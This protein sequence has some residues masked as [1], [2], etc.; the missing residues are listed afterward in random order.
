MT[1]QS[2][3]YS[4]D[5][6]S[7][8]GSIGDVNMVLD[9]SYQLVALFLPIMCLLL[10]LIPSMLILSSSLCVF[11]CPD[12]SVIYCS[13]SIMCHVLFFWFC[14]C[15]FSAYL[16]MN[17][18]SVPLYFQLLFVNLSVFIRHVL[19]YVPRYSFLMFWISSQWLH[20]LALFFFLTA[21]V[22]C[23]L[24]VVFFVASLPISL[25]S[26]RQNITIILLNHYCDMRLY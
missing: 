1:Q 9:F 4:Y 14:L 11:P 5:Q 10:F 24:L 17:L 16:F 15:S 25:Y 20:G 19:G 8:V 21:L 26:A 2:E 23:A 12:L 13:S 3:Y 6:H 7:I 18:Y 22:S